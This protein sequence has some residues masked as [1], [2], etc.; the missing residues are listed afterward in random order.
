MVANRFNSRCDVAGCAES[1]AAVL[2]AQTLCLSHFVVQCYEHLGELDPRAR[3]IPRGA[4]ELALRMAEVEE[5]SSQAL[6]VC[7][8]GQNLNNLERGR[9]LD[10]LLW[11]G[12]LYVLLRDPGVHLLSGIASKETAP[13]LASIARIG[14]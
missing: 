9:L 8:A 7:L 6:R 12:E 2:D 3:R 4:M 13:E 1:A 11:A 10:I 5:C 14:R